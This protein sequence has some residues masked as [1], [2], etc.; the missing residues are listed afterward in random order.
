MT[1]FANLRIATKIAIAFGLVLASMAAMGLFM[2][3]RMGAV[4]EDGRE[5]V[6]NW[7]PSVHQA[8][9][10]NIAAGDRRIA[11]GLLLL[12]A[13]PEEQAAAQTAI[14]A[15]NASMR[16]ARAAYEKL[17]SLPAEREIY[18]SFAR[19]WEGYEKAA[20][21]M[22]AL[23]RQMRTA[24]ATKVFTGPARAPFE[25][26]TAQLDRLVALNMQGATDQGRDAEVIAG[27]TVWLMLVALGLAASLAVAAGL[28]LVRSLARPIGAM[29]AAMDALAGGKLDTA[30]PAVGRRDEVGQMA[31]SMA[32]FRDGLAAAA[33]MTEEQAQQQAARAERATRREAAV[34]AFEGRV[35]EL[36]AAVSAEATELQSTA[37]AMSGTAAETTRQTAAV[38]AASEQTTQNVQTVAAA[39]EELAA[40][41]REIGE[42]VSHSARLVGEVVAEAETTNA[43]VRGL[44][45]AAQKIG[46]VV[47]MINAIAGQ[48]NLLALNATIEAARAGDAGKGFAVV[49]SEVKALASQTARATDEIG[50]QIRA[51]QEATRQSAA[52]IQGITE[53]VGRVSTTAAA[54]A[55]AVEEQGSATQEIARNVEQAAGGTREVSENIGGVSQA[56]QHTAAASSQVLA[57]AGSLSGSSERL[58]AEVDRFLGEMRAA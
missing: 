5:L 8:A 33:R 47:G 14:D 3:Q 31:G 58:R 40:S 9:A 37:E 51:I 21:E 17:I 55:A 46:E 28:V 57:S 36:V 18:D 44:S 39:T 49:A 34:L 35:A 10:I 50:S 20:G 19:H 13:T 2:N 32:V 16:A 54:I 7:L 48:T 38:A 12:A 43:T 45:E 30:I 1:F 27:Q 6:R 42:Q 23:V 52:S 53:Q 56:T 26:A 15:A 24:E 41:I 25:Q 22:A 29:S 4:V 11:A